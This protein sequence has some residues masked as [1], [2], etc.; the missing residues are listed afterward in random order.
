MIVTVPIDVV[1]LSSLKLVPSVAGF[2]A[3]K[4]LLVLLNTFASTTTTKPSPD[5][6]SLFGLGLYK[7]SGSLTTGGDSNWGALGSKHSGQVFNLFH[8]SLT[9]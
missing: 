3:K 7:A 8:S 4:L 2:I 6:L 1:I 5:S 9:H